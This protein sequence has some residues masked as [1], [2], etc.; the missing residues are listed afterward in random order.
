[1]EEL[2]KKID[3]KCETRNMAE[4]D[5]PGGPRFAKNAKKPIPENQKNRKTIPKRSFWRIRFFMFF[6][7]A[8]KMAKRVYE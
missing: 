1:M 7:V 3:E 6:R 5:H 2:F 4:N 8:K